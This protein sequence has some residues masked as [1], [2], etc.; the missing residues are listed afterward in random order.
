MIPCHVVLRNVIFR[1]LML[2][3]VILCRVVLR[4]VILYRMGL[5]CGLLPDDRRT[6]QELASDQNPTG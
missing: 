1:R 2:H 4:D 6:M 3:S 5:L